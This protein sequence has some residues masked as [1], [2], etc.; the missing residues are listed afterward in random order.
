MR[1]IVIRKQL[2]AGVKQKYL[3]N[4]FKFDDCLSRT[5]CFPFSRKPGDTAYIRRLHVDG[6]RKVSATSVNGWNYVLTNVEEYRR[7]KLGISMRSKGYASDEYLNQ[8]V[9]F[10]RQSGNFVKVLYCKAGK[11]FKHEEKLLKSNDSKWY[12]YT[13]NNGFM[14]RT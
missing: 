12:A 7:C 14:E 3:F 2:K 13:S 1:L 4:I 10:E 5:F 6:K 11:Q 8:I 9:W